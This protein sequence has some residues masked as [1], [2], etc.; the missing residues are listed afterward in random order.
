M[1]VLVTLRDSFCVFSFKVIHELVPEKHR[2]FVRNTHK[3]VERGKRKKMES[4][5]NKMVRVMFLN[6]TNGIP[7]LKTQV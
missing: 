4:H 2:K 6:K 3:R 5:T 1:F 7:I